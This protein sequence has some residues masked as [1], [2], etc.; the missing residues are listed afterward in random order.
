MKKL[1]CPNCGNSFVRATYQEGRVERLLSRVN[2]FPFR[3]QLCTNRFRAFYA[4]AHHNTQASDRRQYTRL[5]ASIEAQVLDRN[6]PA[7][8]N[9][10]TDISMDGCTLQTTGFPKGAFIELV[11]KPMVEE[12]TIRI[13]RA[14][15]CSV[16]PLSIG[17]RFLEIPPQ[18][19]RRLA[20]VVL[21]LLVGQGLELT[22]NA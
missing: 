11:L 6:Q 14:M 7:V 21:G 1:N 2:V 22:L 9:R 8:T 17:I 4:G 16:R 12:E 3:C 10:I 18:H 5:T 20:Q 15:V 13:A 19:Y